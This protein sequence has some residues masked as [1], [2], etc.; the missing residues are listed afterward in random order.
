MQSLCLPHGMFKTKKREQKS[1]KREKKYSWQRYLLDALPERRTM[2][3][4]HE[5]STRR[6]LMPAGD[7]SKLLSDTLSPTRKWGREKSAPRPYET[8]PFRRHL[9][10]TLLDFKLRFSHLFISQCSHR[11][12]HVVHSEVWACARAKTDIMTEVWPVVNVFPKTIAPSMDCWNF[13]GNSSVYD[14]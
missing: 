11:V 9:S 1:W 14:G 6:S 10:S 2:T 4:H 5:I 3:M 7:G 8:D 12:F 13:E